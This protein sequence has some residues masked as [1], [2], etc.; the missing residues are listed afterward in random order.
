MDSITMNSVTGVPYASYD[1]LNKWGTNP[2]ILIILSVVIILYYIF[3]ASLGRRQSSV[4]TDGSSS[5]NVMF[6]EVLLWGVFIVLVLLNGMAYFFNIN[7]IASIKNLFSPVPEIDIT[8]NQ[9]DETED[10]DEG[11]SSVPEI[12][13]E[14]QVFH[15]PG[16]D[17]SFE[18]AKALCQAFGARLA[19]YS[20]MDE[21]YQ[22]GADWCS[23]GWSKGQYAYYPTQM[24]KWQ[25]LQKIPGHEHDCGRPG[26]NG[27]YIANPNVK[28]GT[29][30][31]GYKPRITQEEVQLM[32]ETSLYPKTQ[33]EL[34]FEKRVNYWRNR[35]SKILV[36]P[37]NS[38]NWS[39][40]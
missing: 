6:L 1:Y 11:G 35:L 22:D 8:V 31:F 12:K 9:P 17:Y 27:G 18:N 13:L 5:K 37:F 14:K 29:N 39:I 3:F 10:I 26:I 21:A 36:S 25:Q 19:N 15:V 28:F 38:N 16:N 34:N 24:K 33:K 4:P 30:C 40:I 7:I 32:S 23:F 20:E 2:V